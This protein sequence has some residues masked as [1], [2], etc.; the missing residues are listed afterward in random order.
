[1]DHLSFW[2]SLVPKYIIFLFLDSVHVWNHLFS[3]YGL[4][5]ISLL[6]F[7][8]HS[9]IFWFLHSFCIFDWLHLFYI[10]IYIYVF[11]LGMYTHNSF[12]HHYSLA[13]TAEEIFHFLTSYMLKEKKALLPNFSLAMNKNLGY[14]GFEGDYTSQF[15]GNF[16]LRKP[17]YK[18]HPW[19][20]GLVECHLPSW[21]T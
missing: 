12:N 5:F 13:C 7:I 3:I 2:I 15:Y 17:W 20:P 8:F 9:F 6:F 16:I 4:L 14:L 19:S 10:Y 21:T 18:D 1:M 11:L